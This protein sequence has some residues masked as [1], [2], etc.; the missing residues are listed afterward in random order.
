MYLIGILEIVLIEQ[1]KNIKNESGSMTIPYVQ[2]LL[3]ILKRIG[4]CFN[5]RTH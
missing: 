5:V 1:L 4:N 3:E 2:R